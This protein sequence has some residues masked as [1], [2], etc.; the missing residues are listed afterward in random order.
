MKSASKTV[1]SNSSAEFAVQWPLELAAKT[2][3]AVH[4]HE[5]FNSEDGVH[6]A[7]LTNAV[8]EVTSGMPATNTYDS[9]KQGSCDTL[10]M[11]T[12]YHYKQDYNGTVGL[13]L[14][15]DNLRGGTLTLTFKN[16][17][18]SRMSVLDST[19][20]LQ[21]VATLLVVPLD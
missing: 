7:N 1:G 11:C 15:T 14:S 13:H 6:N 3:Y 2:S 19:V 18:G 5:L 10:A 17:D 4:L 20:G 12:G 21:W 8:Y 9:R 16:L